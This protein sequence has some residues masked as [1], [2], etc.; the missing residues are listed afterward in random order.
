[1]NVKTLQIIE[2][3]LMNEKILAESNIEYLLMEKSLSPEEKK[4][5]IMLEL[6]KLKNASL[7]LSFWGDFISKNVIIPKEEDNNTDKN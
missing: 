5:K 1:M 3:E 4:E 7:K 2:G 6:E